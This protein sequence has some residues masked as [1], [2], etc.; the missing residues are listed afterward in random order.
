MGRIMVRNA[1]PVKEFHAVHSQF[2]YT[3]VHMS[4]GWIARGMGIS[5]MGVSIFSVVLSEVASV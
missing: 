4:E 2:R 5:P 3:S 1:P